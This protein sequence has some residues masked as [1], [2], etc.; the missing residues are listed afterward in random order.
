MTPVIYG[1]TQSYI[2][3]SPASQGCLD[4]PPL[5][6]WLRVFLNSPEKRRLWRTYV[7]DI[8]PGEFK[9]WS[10]RLW[11]SVFLLQW[12]VGCH[13]LELFLK[14]VIKNRTNIV[15][16]RVRVWGSTKL[17]HPVPDQR[18]LWHASGHLLQ[19]LSQLQR[20]EKYGWV[21]FIVETTKEN[22]FQWCWEKSTIMNNSVLSPEKSIIGLCHR[23]CGRVT[24]LISIR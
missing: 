24:G 3:A 4:K 1:Q 17:L 7:C 22:N 12:S 9:K 20:E 8:L 19:D 2:T 11:N 5:S 14:I 10:P 21:S 15:V 13:H 6:Y 18:C 16:N 23:R